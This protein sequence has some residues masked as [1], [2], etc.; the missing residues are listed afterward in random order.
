MKNTV[1]GFRK[2]K[3]PTR[4]E[5]ERQ[6]AVEAFVNEYSELCTKHGLQLIP[7]LNVD[8]FRGITPEFKIKPYIAPP[9]PPAPEENTGE[10]AE[11]PEAQEAEK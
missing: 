1:K 4:A 9:T 2:E 6:Q 8:K 7:T 5:V 11:N 3:K 10:E